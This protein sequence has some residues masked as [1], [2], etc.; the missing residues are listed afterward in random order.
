[1]IVSVT[2]S[3]V[4][5]VQQRRR[6]P[7]E[8]RQHPKNASM[9]TTAAWSFG[10]LR[11]RSLPRHRER[12][13]MKCARVP[14]MRWL[15]LHKFT[16][17]SCKQPS[18]QRFGPCICQNQRYVRCA[19][20]H[21]HTL[22]HEDDDQIKKSTNLPCVKKDDNSRGS[23]DGGGGAPGT[24]WAD[25]RV[26]VQWS[27]NVVL[28]A[29]HTQSRWSLQR[30]LR[31]VTKLQLDLI[32]E[33]KRKTSLRESRPPN[34]HRRK[35]AS[36][37]QPSSPRWQAATRHQHGNGTIATANTRACALESH[38]DGCDIT[39]TELSL[40]RHRARRASTKDL[41]T[42]NKTSSSIRSLYIHLPFLFNR[43][44]SVMLIRSRLPLCWISCW[45]AAGLRHQRINHSPPA[46]GCIGFGCEW[47]I[48]SARLLVR[49]THWLWSYLDC[50]RCLIGWEGTW[51][52]VAIHQSSS[53]KHKLFHS[54]LSIFVRLANPTS[55]STKSTNQQI[56][57]EPLREIDWASTIII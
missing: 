45:N 20:H 21:H 10:I 29:T 32:P 8:N 55:T 37:P 46:L 5:P 16:A 25:A 56:T 51:E 27:N 36:E 28:C 13:F 33:R 18:W 50:E 31:R 44:V 26:R 35:A 41:A 53:N 7:K 4:L 1:M 40:R 34:Q 14:S 6:R 2:V 11:C 38:N 47:L 42:K 48:G 49:E 57:L 30:P 12:H 15:A 9:S 52:M 22:T 43:Y 23:N 17:T 3:A 19:H 39:T 54:I 24:F